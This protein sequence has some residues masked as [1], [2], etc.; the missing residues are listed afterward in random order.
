MALH[1][2][3]SSRPSPL[4]STRFPPTSRGEPRLRLVTVVVS[5]HGA[6]GSEAQTLI[7]QV[8]ARVTGAVPYRLLNDASCWATQPGMRSPLLLSSHLR[9][10]PGAGYRHPP[11]YLHGC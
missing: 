9:G 7:R 11:E 5:V 6:L 3:I 4:A 2:A 10:A 8:S 1:T